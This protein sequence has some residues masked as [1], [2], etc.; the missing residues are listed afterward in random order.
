M[1]EID[2][3]SQDNHQIKYTIREVGQ[4]VG[5]YLTANGIDNAEDI[6][7]YITGKNNEWCYIR[8]HEQFLGPYFYYKKT[9]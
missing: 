4:V 7:V 9:K 1:Y 5:Q 3:L 2:S 8:T 6:E